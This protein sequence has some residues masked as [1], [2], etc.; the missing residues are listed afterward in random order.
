[1]CGINGAGIA[2]PFGSHSSFPCFIMSTIV[3]LFV[4]FLFSIAL[5]VILQIM[6]SD[7]LPLRNL[8]TLHIIISSPVY[9]EPV[10]NINMSIIENKKL[11]M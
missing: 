6:A 11:F 1:M 9:L 5:S 10:K 8:Q 7:Y 4:H 2:Y 3:C